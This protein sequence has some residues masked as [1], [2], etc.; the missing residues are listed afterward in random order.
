MARRLL[1]EETMRMVSLKLSLGVLAGFSLGCIAQLTPMSTEQLCDDVIYAIDARIF[2]C[3]GDEDAALAAYAALEEQAQCTASWT[4]H[5][6]VDAQ[7]GC[8]AGMS[9]VSCEDAAAF[10]DDLTA[11]LAADA[12]CAGLFTASGGSAD[13]GWQ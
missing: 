10:G 11:W 7:Y 9:A 4:T 8:V 12:A 2:T 6:D 5:D 3:E 1:L 13:T